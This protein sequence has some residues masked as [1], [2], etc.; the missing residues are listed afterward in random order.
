MFKKQQTTNLKI[1][2]QNGMDHWSQNIQ[3]TLWCPQTWLE[4]P[5]FEDVPIKTSIRKKSMFLIFPSIFPW[6]S[7]I[8]SS[9]FFPW[10]ISSKPGLF[11]V[12]LFIDKGPQRG[13][14]A[15]QVNPQTE[16][17]VGRR[18]RLDLRGFEW[19]FQRGKS[20]GWTNRKLLKM[21]HSLLIYLFKM[22]IFHSKVLVY[23]RVNGIWKGEWFGILRV[24]WDSNGIFMVMKYGYWC[25]CP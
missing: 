13:H 1:P 14:S 2:G 10:D 11:L 5:K 12:V 16:D 3:N 23:Q 21:A 15:A 17:G 20:L 7:H 22:V 9:L 19:D 24:K 8:P 18:P 4:N 25:H 6:C